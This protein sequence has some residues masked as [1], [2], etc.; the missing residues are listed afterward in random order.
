MTNPSTEP[1]VEQVSRF[2]VD[3]QLVV[4]E[5]GDGS[6]HATLEIRHFYL[7]DPR[8]YD[9]QTHE[10]RRR[11]DRNGLSWQSSSN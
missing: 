10:I 5:L 2:D 8:Y 11:V 6:T 3:S 9:D 1:K 7:K 4:I